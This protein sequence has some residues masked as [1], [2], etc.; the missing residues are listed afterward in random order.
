MSLTMS[1]E[2][3]YQFAE[4]IQALKTLSRLGKALLV[5]AFFLGGWVAT[6]QIGQLHLGK[7]VVDMQIG[8]KNQGTELNRIGIWQAGIEGSKYTSLDANRDK[9]QLQQQL[10]EHDKRLTRIEDSISRIEKGIE[11]IEVKIGSKP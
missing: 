3:S 7:D 8:V 10:V 5:G 9:S 11:R 2:Q 1:E 6:I 4:E